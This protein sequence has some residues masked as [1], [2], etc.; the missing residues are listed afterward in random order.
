[1]SAGRYHI[2]LWMAMLS[3]CLYSCS[4]IDEDLSGCGLDNKIVYKMQLVTNIHTELDVQL[5]A[6]DEQPLAQQ[7]LASLDNIF[8]DMAH[9][10]DISFY[11]TD[12]KRERHE[13]H[14]MDASSAEYVVYLPERD[15][16][17]L[18]VANIMDATNV[19]MYSA[20]QDPASVIL[21]QQMADTIDSHNTGIFTARQIIQV[22]NCTET[23]NVDLYMANS[24]TA[25]VVDTSKVSIKGMTV[26]AEGLASGMSVND[27]TYT[28]A[29]NP[30]VRSTEMPVSS[31]Y[32]RTCHYLVT[33]PSS[34]TKIMAPSATKT[35]ASADNSSRSPQQAESTAGGYYKLKAYI[36]LNDG[37]VTENIITVGTPLKAGQL[38]VIKMVMNDDGSLSPLSMDV[39]VSVTLDWKEGGTYEPDL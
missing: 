29:H 39:G 1:M 10:I 30:V 28:F 11:N 12:K 33:F 20:D 14:I 32:H 38:K 18:A 4:V 13:Q 26:M 6:E 37:K 5:G 24:C 16:R 27:S 31:A 15:Y 7:L 9:D 17:H 36:T 22:C 23:Y 19:A 25:L 2:Y 34:D 35:M 8:T 21:Q 3:L